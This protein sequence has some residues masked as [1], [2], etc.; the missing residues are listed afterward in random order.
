MQPEWKWVSGS[1]VGTSH[2]GDEL[3]CQ[4]SNL[5]G[6]EDLDGQACF[7]SCVADGAGSAKHS[8]VG[9]AT[10]CRTFRSLVSDHGWRLSELDPSD[11]A[12]S[13]EG[14][15]VTW[16]RQ[17]RSSIECE[18]ERLNV[19]VRQLACTFLAA[20]VFDNIAGFIQ[21]GDG[22]I[23]VQKK[24]ISGV[25]VWP[26][27]GEYANTTNFLT[28]EDFQLNLECHI[29]PGKIDQLAL[30]SD[31]LERLI[32]KFV[33]KTVHAPFLMPLF[34]KLREVKNSSDLVGPLGNFLG[35]SEV[36]SRTDDD[37]T[38]SLAVRVN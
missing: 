24:D 34:A 32:L 13:F 35:S 25:V 22:A 16:C 33:D 3:P 11:F 8:D 6:V 23:V 2:A 30:F 7:V 14:V 37:K 4:D 20:I 15:A 36:N 31:G 9:S 12:V 19:P 29:V 1:V 28:D 27:S 26:Q 5:A 38:L 10:A 18:A 21:I 17:I